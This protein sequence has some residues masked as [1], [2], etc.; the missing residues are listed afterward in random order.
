MLAQETANP[1]HRAAFLENAPAL[2]V[3]TLEPGDFFGAMSLF[4]VSRW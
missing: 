2:P 1:D 3:A 4:T